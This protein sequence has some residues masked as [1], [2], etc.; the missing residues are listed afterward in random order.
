MITRYRHYICCSTKRPTE[1]VYGITRVSKE[2]G[3]FNKPK[4]TAILEW[5]F[6]HGKCMITFR[7]RIRSSRRHSAFWRGAYANKI[8]SPF[9]WC[10]T[11]AVYI[12]PAR[13]PVEI[14]TWA[15]S[16]ARIILNCIK[17]Q[18]R[19]LYACRSSRRVFSLQFIRC[20]KY[21][22]YYHST[23]IRVSTRMSGYKNKTVKRK[24]DIILV[25]TITSA[26]MRTNVKYFKW[27][28][29]TR[30]FI[31]RVSS[32]FSNSMFYFKYIF[33]PD[34][35]VLTLR[36]GL[37]KFIKRS[38]VSTNYK[39]KSWRKMA[40]FFFNKECGNILNIRA[41]NC[42]AIYNVLS[43]MNYYCVLI[44]ELTIYKLVEMARFAESSR[45]TSFD[46]VRIFWPLEKV[47]AK[48]RSGKFWWDE[49]DLLHKSSSDRP[50]E[51]DDETHQKEI[52]KY[53]KRVVAIKRN[54]LN[55]IFDNTVY[56]F[57]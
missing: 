52:R 54:L 3:H 48:R 21:Y 11:F 56:Q 10:N 50:N 6:V 36:R 46:N 38:K 18:H 16:F 13:I 23:C 47:S 24:L 29:V 43:K 45:C 55:D 31:V 4:D 15:K 51:V 53:C 32:R 30:L 1:R 2:C 27:L 42:S 20:I 57:S 9:L 28:I 14:F 37:N 22:Y 33:N 49:F 5:T 8:Y 40:Y 35:D 19:Q 17:R 44:V 26:P 25:I 39:T 12:F 34:F 7:K 41:V